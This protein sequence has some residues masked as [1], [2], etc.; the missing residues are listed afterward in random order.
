[1]EL[2]KNSHQVNFFHAKLS[3]GLLRLISVN[4]IIFLTAC[5]SMQIGEKDYGCKGMPDGVSC[6]S[7]VDVYNATSDGNVP[8]TKPVTFNAN[9]NIDRIY[10]EYVVPELPDGPVPVRTPAKVMRIWIAPWEDINGNLIV[11]G[12]VYTEIEAR[13][14]V[15]GESEARKTPSFTPLDV[16]QQ[17]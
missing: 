4:S 9:K 12:H 11:S 10:S 6:M 14:W 8:A 7:T 1:M 16:K 17:Q 2:T 5:S 15:I 13:K 3:S